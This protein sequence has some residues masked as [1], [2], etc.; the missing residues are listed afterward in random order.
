VK[1]VVAKRVWTTDLSSANSRGMT[2]SAIRTIGVAGSPMTATVGI[3]V[4][5]SSS[6]TSVVVPER[7]IATT[8]S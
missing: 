1:A 8:R 4:R 6:S 5:R 7:Q 2:V 3:P